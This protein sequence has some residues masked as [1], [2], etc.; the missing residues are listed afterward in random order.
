MIY[1]GL[2]DTDMLDAPGTNKL[3][4]HLVDHLRD[5]FNC[6]MILRHQ[7]LEDSRVPCTR[8]NGCASIQLKQRSG[9]VADTAKLAGRIRPIML[10][11]CPAGSDPGLCIT[12]SVPAVVS[13][14]GQRAKRELMAQAEARQIAASVGMFLEGLGGTQDGVIG[15]LAAVGLMA[16]RNDGRVVYLGGHDQDLLDITGSLPV[17]AIIA[18]G[19]DEVR[20]VETNEPVFRGEVLLAKRLRPNFRGGRVVLYVAR[21]ADDLY[22][23]VRVT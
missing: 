22:E 6:R 15:A 18:R 19:I 17:E 7:L 16:T 9:V 1:V 2:D 21:Q 5:E 10:G 20:N 12:G 11:W 14:W 8:K 4:R 23:A 3:A 13:E